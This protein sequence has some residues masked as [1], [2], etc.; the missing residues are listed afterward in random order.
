METGDQASVSIRAIAKS[1]GV[2]PPSIYLHFADKEGLLHE[3]CNRRFAEM[4]RHMDEAGAAHKDPVE[5]LGARG[6]AY[7]RF[8]LEHPE[9]YRV[10]MMTKEELAE[11]DDEPGT[12]QGRI[13]FE[14]HVEA[15]ARCIE[16]GAFR[17]DDPVAVAIDLWAGVHGL[18][19]LAI[20][21]PGFPWPDM[22][23]TIDHL[24]E[25]QVKG[26]LA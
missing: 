15:V 16:T 24:M 19:S 25:S 20:T 1:A 4:N 21:L 10:L 5:S 6:R 14:R 7:I 23:A 13:A 12:S 17:A 11:P 3:V 8:A 2:T 9:H 22:D 18:A 26:F